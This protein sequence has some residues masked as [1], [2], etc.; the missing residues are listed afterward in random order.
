[1]RFLVRLLALTLGLA[2]ANGA[3]AE[4]VVGERVNCRAAART[5]AAPLGVLH[6]GQ[7]VPVL[8]SRR[9][10]S[11]VDPAELPACWV[12]SD[13]LTG[14]GAAGRPYASYRQPAHAR[15]ATASSRRGFF[16]RPT[17]RHAYV[18]G[19][20][21]RHSSSRISR[22]RSSFGGGSCP[23]SGS[24]VCI[25]PRGGRYCITSGGNKRYGV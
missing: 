16:L 20:K 6:H 7:R 1:M 3:A 15:R 10:W 2:L 4:T 11:Y 17:P 23:C 18:A 9:G 24:N 8:S 22:P 25:G 5:T 19:A 21:Y 12:R 14:D 13:L